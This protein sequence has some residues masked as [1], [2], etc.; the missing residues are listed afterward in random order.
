MS[1]YTLAFPAHD[2]TRCPGARIPAVGVGTWHVKPE[3]TATM[4]KCALQA[5]YRH[6]DT[7]LAYGNEKEVG[8]G[9]RQSG[10]PKWELWVTTKVSR[11]CPDVMK[12]P[13]H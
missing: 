11:R 8:E 10:I 9:V 12:T 5:G 7:S 3:D 2:D 13:T 4:V 6:V 1:L